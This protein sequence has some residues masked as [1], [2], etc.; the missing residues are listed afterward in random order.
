MIYIFLHIL[1]ILN[2]DASRHQCNTKDQVSITVNNCFK[3]IFIF[4]HGIRTR[5][6]FS[7]PFA[8]FYPF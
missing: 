3:F 7:A 6:A 5:M 1:Q 4:V 8:E 2:P